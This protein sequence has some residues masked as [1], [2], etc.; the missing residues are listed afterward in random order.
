MTEERDNM[1]II[2][3]PADTSIKHYLKKQGYPLR[4]PCGSRAECAACLIRV[5]RGE[6]DPTLRDILR[7]PEK[8]VQK[9]WRLGCQAI[10]RTPVTI[11]FSKSIVKQPGEHISF[12]KKLF[13]K[14]D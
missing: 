4:L 9:G 2:D 14:W 12:T 6:L 8:D 1:V 7:L 10:T 13:H 3:I 5:R 11:E